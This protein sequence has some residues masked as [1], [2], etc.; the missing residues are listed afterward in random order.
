[1]KNARIF[2]S[3]LHLL[4]APAACCLEC[5]FGNYFYFLNFTDGRFTLGFK[6]ASAS[7]SLS[8][9]KEGLVIARFFNKKPDYIQPSTRQP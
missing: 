3:T 6:A 2:N 5:K 1:M 7:F 4:S 9:F 8:S